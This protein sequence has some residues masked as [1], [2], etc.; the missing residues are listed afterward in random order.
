M[1]SIL[2]CLASFLKKSFMRL[3]FISMNYFY[4]NEN[5]K[6]FKNKSKKREYYEKCSRK[7]IRRSL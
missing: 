4:K 5:N 6:K 2:T 7:N 3:R 1:S